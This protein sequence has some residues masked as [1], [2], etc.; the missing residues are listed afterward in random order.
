MTIVDQQR[1]HAT[2]GVLA[3]ADHQV[4]QRLR[5]GDHATLTFERPADPGEV[6][7]T[8]EQGRAVAT[9]G[10][11]TG[12]DGVATLT[13]DIP[14]GGPYDISSGDGAVLARDVLV[15]DLWVLA[16]QSNM[17]GTAR[18][19]DLEPPSP[20][21]HLLDMARQWQPAVEPLHRLSISPDPVHRGVTEE[22]QALLR[23]YDDARLLGAGLGLAFGAAYHRVTGVP[24]G[25]VATAH[26]GS[27]LAQWSPSLAAHRGESMYGSFLLSLE[28]CGGRVA[29]VLWY[30]G[31]SETSPDTA[32]TFTDDLTGLVSAMRRDE[33]DAALPFHH[34]QLGRYVADLESRDDVRWSQVREAQRVFPADGMASAIDLDLDDLIHISTASLRRLGRRLARLASGE[35]ET[36]RLRDIAV[37]PDGLALTVG[38]EGV[39]GRLSP[40]GHVAGYSLH[41][42]HGSRRAAV[43]HAAVR[44]DGCSVRILLSRP[45]AADDHLAYAFGLDPLVALRDEA[46]MSA[47]AFGPLPLAGLRG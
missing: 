10:T 42:A 22:E 17:A 40:E 47:P 16:G 26:G 21:V 44:A 29:G 11:G 12:A 1:G 13:L 34:V 35:A 15:G 14:V 43:V 9:T 32:F 25:L 33:G 24:V 7:V 28:A 39:S 37:D 3:V 46:D 31:E 41:D 6:R 4:L 8:D 5:G 36:L 45:V 2:P 23:A 19:V 20:V 18:M 30:Q 27:S 38:Y